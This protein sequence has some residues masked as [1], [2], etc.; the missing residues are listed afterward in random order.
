MTFQARVLAGLAIFVLSAC[1]T[2]QT[3][4]LSHADPATSDPR[5]N[6]IVIM[7]DDL[8]WG[9]IGLNGAELI[10]T[11]HIDRIG[12]DGI[13]L[14]SFY[15]GS[16]VC[17]PSR[18]A[19]LT[20]RY[21]IRFGMQ[22]VIF[23]GSEDGLPPSEVTIAELLREAGYATGMIGKWHLG[24]QDQYWPTAHGFDQFYGVA[25]S[26]DMAPFD[27]YSGK[28]VIESPVDQT[29]LTQ[30]YAREARA[31]IR[32]NSDR[33]FFLYYAETFPHIPL[34]VP[35]SATGQS[36]AGF[37]GDVVE[38][39]DWGIGEILA[40]LDEAGISDNT[41]I[42]VTSDNGPWFEGDAGA[43]RDRKGGMHEGGYRVPFVARWPEQIEAGQ[44]SDT[45]TSAMD[46]LPTLA[47]LAGASVPSDRAIDGR[48]ILPVLK[49]SKESPHEVLFFFDGNDLVGAR[50]ERFR[51][52][53]RTFYRTFNVPFEQFATPLLFDLDTDPR[54]RFSYLREHPEV[55]ER[56]MADVRRMRAEVADQ[57]K[58]P[59][60]PRAPRD[61]DAPL[62]PQLDISD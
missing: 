59:F 54:E 38:H 15:A 41:L 14:T 35:D 50:D 33:P 1:G 37:Y 10:E 17:T 44:V 42:L 32:A 55:Y 16:N 9:D 7:A 49:G 28:Q 11:P 20:G 31:F 18:A 46:L 25:Y 19:L 22:H 30:N 36:D 23:P 4:P 58:D 13:Q 8:G 6:I 34:F 2:L 21:P 45:V 47:G 52:T 48:D 40:A 12:Q 53:L 43:F 3:A 60:N 5:P 57:K 24:H 51:L 56:L 62:G 26:N 29:Q 27:L 61:P 39:L